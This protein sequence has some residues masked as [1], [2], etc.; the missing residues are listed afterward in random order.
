MLGEEASIAFQHLVK[1]TVDF[2]GLVDVFCTAWENMHYR[3]KGLCTAT[4][5]E[6]PQHLIKWFPGVSNFLWVPIPLRAWTF[7]LCLQCTYQTITV[8]ELARRTS[9][10]N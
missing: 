1:A 6:V 9:G 4:S 3:W 7:K 5:S 2:A 10:L 8:L